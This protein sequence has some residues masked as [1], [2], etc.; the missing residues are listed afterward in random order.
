MLVHL[1]EELARSLMVGQSFDVHRSSQTSGL[2]DRPTCQHD[3][4]LEL[5]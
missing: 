2:R 3:L 5:Y 4:D 1:L